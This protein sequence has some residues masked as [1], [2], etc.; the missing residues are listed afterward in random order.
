M[1]SV[2]TEGLSGP[3]LWTDRV[4]WPPLVSLLSTLPV[5]TWPSVVLM[6]SAT[7]WGGP[8]GAAIAALGSRTPARKRP[9]AAAPTARRNT[10]LDERLGTMSPLRS[11]GHGVP[12]GHRL[13]T[14]GTVRPRTP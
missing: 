7:G 1:T 14:F 5:A 4:P 12:P 6:T 13:M 11:G 8:L 9:E 3:L 10:G 2:P